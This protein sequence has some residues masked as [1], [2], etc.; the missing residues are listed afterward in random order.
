MITFNNAYLAKPKRYSRQ[1]DGSI[2]IMTGLLFP[3]LIILAGGSVDVTRAYTMKAKAQ[4]TLDSTVLAMARSRLS[5]D[6][7][8][9]QGKTLFDNNLTLS[10]IKAD[11]QDAEFTAKR[12]G[13][14]KGDPSIVT[15]RA[16]LSSKSSFLGI[17]G[18]NDL[19]VGVFSEATKPNPLPYEIAM[20]L[21]VS[22]SMNKNLNGQPRI[23]RLRDATLNL[24]DRLERSSPKE[25]PPSISLVPYSTSV[26]I[27]GLS[28]GILESVSVA[29]NPAGSGDVWAA[30]RFRGQTGAGYDLSDESPDTALMPFVTAAEIGDSEPSAKMQPLTDNRDIYR[31]AVKGL[32]ANGFTSAHTGMIW[33]IYALSPK[34]KSVWP[35]D[36]KEY[37]TANKI[38]VLLTDGAFNTTHN[39]GARSRSDGDESNAYFQSACDL[40]KAQN[41]TIYAVALSL[42]A[43]SEARLSACAAGSGGAML[44]ANSAQG[45]EQAFEEIAAQIGGLRI[46]S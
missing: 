43:A 7:I 39:I 33:G 10:N 45:L 40:A 11:L 32:T 30:E 20:V 42:D 4:K 25:A 27:G 1:T 46:S 31:N 38:I 22:G 6:E 18:M 24:F 35:K 9:Q 14:D 17:F 19:K 21:D 26:N 28:K 5:D 23:A 44:S 37:G 41:V 2:S 13:A 15:G 8:G 12:E 34:W 36:P 3:L 16:T 29:G